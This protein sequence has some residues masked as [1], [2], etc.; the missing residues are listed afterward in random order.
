M[1]K[2]KHRE[3]KELANG[4]EVMEELGMTSGNRRLETLV[5]LLFLSFFFFFFSVN[6]PCGFA[7]FVIFFWRTGHFEYCS[8]VTVEIRFLTLTWCFCCYLI[9]ST[10]IHLFSEFFYFS[11]PNLYSLSCVVPKV[12]VPYS[13][14]DLTKNSLKAWI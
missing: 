11:P 14:S 5:L 6:G 10:V 7:C 8:V 2:L 13:A 12:C 4:T 9:K 1:R 3:F